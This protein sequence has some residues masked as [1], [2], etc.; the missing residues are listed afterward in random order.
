[1]TR[2]APELALKH[3]ATL[4]AIELDDPAEAAA[5]EADLASILGYVELLQSVPTDGVEP[6]TT[7]AAPAARI[8]LRDD[9]ARPELPH[10]EAL[11][12]AP[13]AND[14]GFVVPTFVGS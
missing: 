8:P 2:A 12:A 6:M 11:R 13:Q 14:E 1:M 7:V 10:D 9:A 3:L 5:L 4:A